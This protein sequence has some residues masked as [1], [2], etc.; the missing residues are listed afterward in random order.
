MTEIGPPKSNNTAVIY[1]I[2]IC[3]A[4]NIIFT[5]SGN[6]KITLLCYLLF[7]I[8]PQAQPIFSSQVSAKQKT[9]HRLPTSIKQSINYI[10]FERFSR[11]NFSHS[12]RG[13]YL[14]DNVHLSSTLMCMIWIHSYYRSK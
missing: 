10:S 11:K 6:L 3:V 4:N 9:Y 12:F 1:Q 2:A 7:E 14:L 8:S 13:N 5:C